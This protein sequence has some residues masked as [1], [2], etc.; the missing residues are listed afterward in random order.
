VQ[1]MLANAVDIAA[2]E[3][4]LLAPRFLGTGCASA[5][6]VRRVKP[7]TFPLRRSGGAGGWTRRPG[8]DGNECVAASMALL[9]DAPTFATTPKLRARPAAASCVTTP[10]ATAPEAQIDRGCVAPRSSDRR[11]RQRATGGVG[12]S[13]T[14]L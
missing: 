8:E 7:D 1:S 12:R 3:T 2:T 14:G 13:H 6:P 4:E 5:T 10:T 11:P 9:P